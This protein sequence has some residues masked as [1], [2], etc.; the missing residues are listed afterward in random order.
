MDRRQFLRIGLVSAGGAAALPSVATAAP[1]Q[2]SGGGPYGSLD[3]IDPDENG[4]ILPEGFTSRIVAVGGEPVGDTTYDWHIFPDGAATFDDGE[5]GWYHVC[6][7]EVFVA[8]LGGVSAI[9]FGSDGEILDAYPLLVGSVANCAGG[10]TPWGTWLSCEEDLLEQGIVWECDPTGQ[11]EAVAHPAMGKWAHEAVAVDPVEERLYMTQDNPTGLL[12]RYTPTAYP[13]L[14]HGLL[15]AATVADN[16]AVTWADVPDPSG[17]SAPTREQVEGATVFLGGEGIWYHDDLIYFCTK[18]DNVV[19][20]IDL[21]AQLY[22]EIY[23]PTPEEEAADTAILSGVDNITV[24]EGTGDLFI[25]EDGGNMEVVVITPDGDV[26]PFLR[27]A[28][29]HESE[30]TGPVFNPRRDRLYFS[31]QRGPSPKAVRDIVPGFDSP[32]TNAGITYEVSGPFRGIVAEPVETTTT[33]EVVEE[34]ETAE[35]KVSPTTIPSPT[36]TLGQA[37]ENSTAPVSS[38]DDDGNDGMVIGIGVGVAAA[39][40]AG[41]ALLALR[42]RRSA[43]ASGEPDNDADKAT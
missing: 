8:G 43:G 32:L 2:A 30:I 10:P 35:P 7:S 15:E 18:Y 9:H 6:N 1:T 28:D 42:N 25:A 12:Y 31:S 39:A 29:Q 17:E 40:V 34:P 14:S 19:H 21:R 33:T 5:D 4:V 13:D 26:A 27:V 36:T 20:S 37:A 22:S 16:G 24:D 11:R 41:G 3:G 38:D 23:R